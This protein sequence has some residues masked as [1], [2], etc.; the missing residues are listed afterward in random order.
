[1]TRWTIPVQITVEAGSQ[2]EAEEDVGMSLVDTFGSDATMGS[3]VA[4]DDVV[5]ADIYCGERESGCECM[6]TEHDGD[7]HVCACGGSW[8][9]HPDGSFTIH[10]IPGDSGTHPKPPAELVARLTAERGPLPWTFPPARI[11]AQRGDI[12]FIKPLSLT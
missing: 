7:R 12:R 2:R 4:N 5:D 6:L 8:E 10:A 11:K 1:V 3:A 9:N